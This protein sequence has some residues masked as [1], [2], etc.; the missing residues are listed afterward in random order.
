LLLFNTDNIEDILIGLTRFFASR[1]CPAFLVGGY[2]RDSLLSLPSQDID[3]TVAGDP[4]LLGQELARELGGAFVPLSLTHGV[5][6]IVVRGPD[7]PPWTIDV[8]GLSGSIEEDLARRDFTIN[9]LALPL[10][11]WLSNHWRESILDP[12][13][14]QEDLSKRRIRTVSPC[15]FQEDAGRLLRAVRLA[16]RLQFRLEPETARLIR[17][18]APQIGRVSGE[19]VRDEFLAIL[20]GDDARGQLEVLDR[21]DLLCRIIPEL[22]ITK[23]VEQPRVHYWDVWGHLLHTVE[24]AERVTGGHQNSAIYSFVPWTPEAEEYFNQEVSDGHSRRTILKLAGLLHDIAKPQT[25]TQDETGRTRFFGHPELGAEMAATRLAQLRLSSRG[26]AMVT[27]MVEQHLRPTNMQHGAEMPTRR[28]T[29]RYFRDLGDVAIDTL[30]LAMADYLAAKG[31]ELS[32]DDW[33]NHARMMT[34]ILQ[35]G[36]E[37][38]RPGKPDRLITG[39]DLMQHFNL[40]PGPEIGVLL[41][42]INEARAAG[43]ISTQEEALALAAEALSHQQSS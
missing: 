10:E 26:A 4:Q 8:T 16:A 19:R 31:P 5:A 7:N 17:A 36:A 32:P 1:Q 27:K 25:K 22:A 2:L 39:H 9:T 40:S 24:A 35:I 34:Y 20:A 11:S 38:A 29:Y 3:V 28:A 14:G 42:K 15:V 23:G 37:Q 21:L 13:N 41:E 12:F 33:V 43:E 18:E 6:R 30:Y